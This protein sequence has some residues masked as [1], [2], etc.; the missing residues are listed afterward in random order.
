LS[1][2]LGL[3]AGEETMANGNIEITVIDDRLS[4]S[5]AVYGLLGW[6]TSRS[7]VVRLGATESAAEAAELADA[8]CKANK[9]HPPRDGW[10]WNLE[11]PKA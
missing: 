3:R 8:F 10:N 7:Q 6:L 1:E 11:H 9:L 2:W 4:A 5:E